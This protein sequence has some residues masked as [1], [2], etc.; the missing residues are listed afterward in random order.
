MTSDPKT[1][2]E[3]DEEAGVDTNDPDYVSGDEGDSYTD[4]NGNQNETLD[5]MD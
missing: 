5:G 3:K 4:E 1:K 2:R